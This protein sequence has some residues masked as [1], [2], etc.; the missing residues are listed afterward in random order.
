MKNKKNWSKIIKVTTYLVM[1]I[2]YSLSFFIHQYSV[3]SLIIGIILLLCS[4][5]VIYL[6]IIEYSDFS[7]WLAYMLLFLYVFFEGCKLVINFY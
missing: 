1:S 3:L 2:G 5:E 6:S 7:E 4:V